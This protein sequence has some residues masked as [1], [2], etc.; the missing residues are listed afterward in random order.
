M[1]S[2]YIG[3]GFYISY[4][5]F[6]YRQ[7]ERAEKVSDGPLA[8]KTVIIYYTIFILISVTFNG[9]SY[10]NSWLDAFK[11][12]AVNYVFV[13]LLYMVATFIYK[14][15]IKVEFKAIIIFALVILLSFTIGEIAY[16]TR[17]FG[18]P[19]N[20]EKPIKINYFGYLDSND[21]GLSS[22]KL[23][24]INLNNKQVYEIS[25]QL[26]LNKIKKQS[27]LKEKVLKLLDAYRL[28]IID[29]AYTSNTHTNLINNI[30]FE[31]NNSYNYSSDINLSFKDLVFISQLTDVNIYNYDS[32]YKLKDLLNKIPKKQ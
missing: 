15:R 5:E 29:N 9:L 23:T 28:K 4:H 22:Y 11:F 24:P 30:H 3:T 12:N 20:Y 19:Y 14:R 18:L 27:Q 13:F 25:F 32:S 2:I 10:H 26:D 17:A 8:Y 1:L 16:K 21:E 7:V 6:V 31:A